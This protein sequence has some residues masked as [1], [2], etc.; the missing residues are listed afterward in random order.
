M[1]LPTKTVVKNKAPSDEGAVE[2]TRLRERKVRL[3]MYLQSFSP[4]VTAK[5][6]HLSTAV[7]VGAVALQRCPPDTRTL[8]RGRQ[9][10]VYRHPEAFSES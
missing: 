7:S 2:C 10:I 5:P 1:K 3:Y 9:K 8:V 6:C 4:S